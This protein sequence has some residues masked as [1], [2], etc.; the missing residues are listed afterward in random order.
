MTPTVK[1]RWIAEA[2]ALA[3]LLWSLL[4]LFFFDRIGE[5]PIPIHY[6]IR[7]VA[8]AFGTRS[9]LWF[10]MGF[11]AF[12]YLLLTILQ[13]FPAVLNY[14]I[15]VTERNAAALHRLGSLLVLY[16]KVILALMFGYLNQATLSTA[17]GGRAGLNGWILAVLMGALLAVLAI[18]CVRMISLREK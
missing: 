4:P 11:S 5:H 16:L 6:N 15:R 14:P 7:G 1:Y 8:D 2:L 9:S 13:R 10:P 18:F 12:I 3:G 17:L